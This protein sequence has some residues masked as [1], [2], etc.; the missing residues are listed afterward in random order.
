MSNAVIRNTITLIFLLCVISLSGCDAM[1]TDS[2]NG[3]AG[4]DTEAVDEGNMNLTAVKEADKDPDS[5]DVVPPIDVFTDELTE[6]GEPAIYDEAH[7]F[8]DGL[9]DEEPEGAETYEI[10][11]EMPYCRVSVYNMEVMADIYND[12]SNCNL[13]RIAFQTYFDI[14][15]GEPGETYDISLVEGSC[16]DEGT[17]VTLQAEAEQFPGVI[18]YVEYDKNEKQFGIDSEYLDASL[19]T[20]RKN[21]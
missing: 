19:E 9:P 2:Q 6:E 10:D 17:L 21:K 11:E 5:T 3:E 4:S 12:Y 13:L 8:L 16:R 7:G 15:T 14:A 1:S 18:F 20:L